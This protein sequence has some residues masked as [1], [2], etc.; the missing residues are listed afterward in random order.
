M[1]T[2]LNGL[3]MWYELNIKLRGEVGGLAGKGS[4]DQRATVGLS[5][6]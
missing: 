2:G 3:R 4:N 5:M 1:K 6:G